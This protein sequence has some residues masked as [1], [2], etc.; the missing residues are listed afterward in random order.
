MFLAALPLTGDLDAL[1]I[2][3]IWVNAFMIASLNTFL[4]Q[5]IY[6]SIRRVHLLQWVPLAFKLLHSAFF[7][8]IEI[9]RQI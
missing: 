2:I 1:L 9:D 7:A 6:I 5:N 3:A 8:L 4:A